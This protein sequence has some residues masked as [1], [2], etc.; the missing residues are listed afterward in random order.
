MHIFLTPGPRLAPARWCFGPGLGRWVLTLA[1]AFAIPTG[2]TAQVPLSGPFRVAEQNPI[3]GLFLTPRPDRADLLQGGEVE[4]A[5]RSRF[6][7]V[8]EFVRQP[9]VEATFDYER[10]SNTFELAWAPSDRF[11]VGARIATVTSFGGALDGLIQWYHQR[12]NLPNGDREDVENGEFEMTLVQDGDTLMSVPS[13]SSISDPVLWVA[14][15]LAS[16]DRSALALRVS[17]KL[18]VGSDDL[19]SGRTDLAVQLDGRRSGERWTF[20]A[21]LAGG[22]LRA[23][24]VLEAVT[25]SW[26]LSWHLGAVRRL[27][28]RWGAMAQFQGSSGYLKG[29]DSSKLNASPINLGV[30]VVGSTG[31]GW[32]W[33]AAFTEDVRPNSPGVD[34][35]LDFHL[36]RVVSLGR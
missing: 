1:L 12:L 27:G 34:F 19:S 5:L 22:T 31:G 35:T 20:H 17:T 13:G 10:W 33:Q 26:A 28:E 32:S 29:L 24:E 2:V 16:S 7:N 36:S 11:E 6:S 4:F 3:Y 23:P 18:P 9:D 15:P 30:G 14:L 8:F 21:G 25:R